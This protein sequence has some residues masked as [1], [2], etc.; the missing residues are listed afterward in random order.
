MAGFTLA[1]V[2]VSTAIV[3]LV[4]G[5]VINAYIQAGQRIEWTGYSLAAQSLAEETIEQAKSATWDPA[6]TPPVNNLTN[7][8]LLGTVYNAGTQTY[9]GYSIG[10]LDVPYSSTNSVP[11]TNFVTIEMLN[12]NTNVNVQIQFVQVK[13]VWPFGLRAKNLYF[14]NT[15][16]TLLAPDNR[17]TSSF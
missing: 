7:M 3:A 4:F 11:A 13:T 8:N 9:T 10:I 17:S 14:T 15:V 2:V 1:E 12:D 5:G 16:C 6:Q